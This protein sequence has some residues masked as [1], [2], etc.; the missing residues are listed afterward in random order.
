MLRSR[1]RI[2][3]VG[4]TMGVD[5]VARGLAGYMA[6][7]PGSLPCNPW[8]PTVPAP[9]AYALKTDRSV[10]IQTGQIVP[11]PPGGL[12][13]VQAQGPVRAVRWRMPARGRGAIDASPT[14]PRQCS[15]S[16]RPAR[17]W[18]GRLAFRGGGGWG[19]PGPADNVHD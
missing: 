18:P 17:S 14:R 13:H 6:V 2:R 5:G 1:P 8:Q 15:D 9:L 10:W 11:H 7:T 19:K 12:S 3:T 16:G 4:R